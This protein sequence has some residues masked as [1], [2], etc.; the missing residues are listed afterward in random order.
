M[1][2]MPDE[3]YKPRIIRHVKERNAKMSI[4]KHTKININPAWGQSQ[5]KLKSRGRQIS[6]KA[7]IPRSIKLLEYP[8]PEVDKS[9]QKSQY[10]EA[11]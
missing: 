2:K 9:P 8:C 7:D 4:A 1:T 3:P 6:S 5:I 11:K 10:P